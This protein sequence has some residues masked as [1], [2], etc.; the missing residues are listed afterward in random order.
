MEAKIEHLSSWIRIGKQ[1]EYDVTL[2]VRWLSPTEVEL[3]GLDKPL[4]YAQG[5]KIVKL[6]TSLGVERVLIQRLR[7]GKLTSHYLKLK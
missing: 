6:L 4:N 5:R 3:V 2:G 7:D 1:P